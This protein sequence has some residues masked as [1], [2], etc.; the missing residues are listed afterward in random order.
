MDSV[1]D[2]IAGWWWSVDEDDKGGGGG[3]FGKA[4]PPYLS[5]LVMNFPSYHWLSRVHI[6]ERTRDDGGQPYKKTP[7]TR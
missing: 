3:V 7:T 2:W 1:S 5:A 4:L 6:V